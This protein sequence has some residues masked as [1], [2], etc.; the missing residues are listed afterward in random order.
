MRNSKILL[1]SVIMLFVACGKGIQS[2]SLPQL[3]VMI[4]DDF[5]AASDSSDYSAQYVL[6][7]VENVQEQV[8]LRVVFKNLG[9][10][11]LKI[12]SITF[13]ESKAFKWQSF[14]NP[15]EDNPLIIGPGEQRTNSWLIYD[16]S[17]Q[18]DAAVLTIKS[19]DPDNSVYKIQILPPG[20]APRIHV[21]DTSWTFASATVAAPETHEFVIT[22]LGRTALVVKDVRL[23]KEGNQSQG[24]AIFE[25]PPKDTIV[26]PLGA[27]TVPAQGEKA[28][29]KVSY[30]PS[31]SND[32]NTL[33]IE[34]NDPLK[35]T[36]TIDLYGNSKPGK[37]SV[38][39]AD[40]LK[41]FIDFSEVTN[42]GQTCTKRVIISNVGE[43]ML[44]LKMPKAVSDKHQ[45]LVNKAYTVKWYTGGGTQ[46]GCDPYQKAANGAE[47][48]SQYPLA[49][50]YT[51]DVVVT[52]KSLGE[53]GV[54]ADLVIPYIGAMQGEAR[55]HMVGGVSKGEF[56]IA[57]D[58]A[59]GKVMFM[60]EKGKT[61][62]RTIVIMNRGNGPLN[63]TAIELKNNNQTNP[64]AFTLKDP[65]LAGGTQVPGFG[66]LPVVVHFNTNYQATFASGNLKITYEDPYT[67]APT[68]MNITLEG[69]S[70]LKDVQLPVANPGNS[71]EYANIHPG[72]TVIL[73]GSGSQGGT[74]KLD[75]A[76]YFWFMTSKPAGSKVFLNAHG[77]PKVAFTPD[78][79][80]D[81][82]I[83]LVVVTAD[84]KTGNAYFSPEAV[85]HLNVAQ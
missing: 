3:A 84:P 60:V 80:G 53:K 25:R 81:Y 67:G 12:T 77:S 38:S 52:Y 22:N 50:S 43:G 28:V 47:L 32:T 74:Y 82:E 7:P 35:P 51:V 48:G 15:T 2:G 49:P 16:P 36:Y 55:I 44:Q 59:S 14:Y 23:E 61:Q 1:L 85:L 57:P 78:V 13:S 10:A 19:N 73:D 11:D 37:I 69:H 56:D 65:S 6:Q 79:A 24:F 68:D 71:S 62:D 29:V 70:D 40:Q 46:S 41:G 4:H 9:G 75:N 26:K 34:S 21:N 64:P 58:F 63:I 17:A 30:T 8:K 76:G 31:G 66:L 33:I 5:P 18:Q 45:D 20:A 39:Y 27:H 54:D 42:P 72:D 83:R